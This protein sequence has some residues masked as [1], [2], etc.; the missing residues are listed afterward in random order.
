ML[1]LA[2]ELGS[3][4]QDRGLNF[5]VSSLISAGA[6]L[7]HALLIC[8]LCNSSDSPQLSQL[9]QWEDVP[10]EL[11]TWIAAQPGLK[12]DQGDVSSAED[13]LQIHRLLCRKE[14]ALTLKGSGIIAIAL[15]V[16]IRYYKQ[17]QQ[18]GRSESQ[19][20]GLT[21][22]GVP[23]H[24]IMPRK[25]GLCGQRVLDDA[26]ARYKKSD[27]QRYV[28]RFLQHGCGLPLCPRNKASTW[29]MPADPSVLYVR[30]D[31]KKLA[32]EPRKTSWEDYFLQD[33]Q[34]DGSERVV[35]IVCRTCRAT[36]YEDTKPRWTRE[37]QPRYVL[38]RPR[39]KGCN[40]K[41]SNWTPKDKNVLWVDSSK[42]SRKWS[43]LLKRPGFNKN[44][45]LNNPDWYFP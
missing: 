16:A 14:P 41:N 33:P 27:P 12:I 39:C 28:L 7:E 29:A 18:I 26:L 9:D 35:T 21:V 15:D 42:L 19:L 11:Q 43:N 44:D 31:S 8:G 5:L 36:Q 40:L 20:E 24:H 17:V 4:T 1:Q 3:P 22:S 2:P 6:S 45:V 10:L 23:P 13:L 38:R 25:C 30:P 32:A 37:S 34:L